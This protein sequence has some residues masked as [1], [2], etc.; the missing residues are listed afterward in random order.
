LF[1]SFQAVQPKL[2]MHFS[3]VVILEISLRNLHC[4]FYERCMN[5]THE[6]SVLTRLNSGTGGEPEQS[7]SRR[8]CTEPWSDCT[9]LWPESALVPD[10]SANTTTVS[11]LCSPIDPKSITSF[12]PDCSIRHKIACFKATA[13]HHLPL[14]A[15]L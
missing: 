15:R 3:Y 8:C 13:G 9:C 11:G 6:T 7:L 4:V 1:S 10:S 5:M 12:S 14:T 2:C